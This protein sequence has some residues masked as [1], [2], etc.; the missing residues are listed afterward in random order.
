LIDGVSCEKIGVNEYIFADLNY[1]CY[2]D[3]YKNMVLFFYFPSLTF[4][5]LIVPISFV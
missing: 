4:W 1:K 5:G 2:T 3:Q